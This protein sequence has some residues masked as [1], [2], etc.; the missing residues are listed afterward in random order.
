MDFKSLFRGTIV[1]AALFVLLISWLAPHY[2]V[3]Y[4]EPP[5]ALAVSCKEP[6]EW[7]LI[8]MQRAQIAAVVVGAILGAVTVFAYQ[9][10][11]RNKPA[12]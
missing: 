2:L 12:Y 11:K 10:R 3:W 5:V 4:F 8:R 9:R 7:A 1:G 6:V